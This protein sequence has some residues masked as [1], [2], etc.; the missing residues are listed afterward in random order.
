MKRMLIL[1]L[2]SSPAMADQD[3]FDAGYNEGYKAIRGDMV[4]TPLT[5]LAPL[6]PLNSTDFREGIKQGYEDGQKDEYQ[7]YDR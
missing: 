7:D 5:P 3:G 4:L 2:L 6:T 1:L